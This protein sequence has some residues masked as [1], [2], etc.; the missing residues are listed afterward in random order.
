MDG[1]IYFPNPGRETIKVILSAEAID[2]RVFEMQGTRDF[3]T[4]GDSL[5]SPLER[6]LSHSATR[7]QK[8][9]APGPSKWGTIEAEML[10]EK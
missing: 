2:T 7:G 4:R 6:L 1:A 3:K 10:V 8:S 5:L 9:L